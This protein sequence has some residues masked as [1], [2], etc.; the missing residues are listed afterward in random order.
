MI[1][2]LIADDHAIFR[3]GIG[4]IIALQ[5]DMCVC[6]EAMN[7]ED[8]LRQLER[9]VSTVLV[10]DMSMPG[11]SGIALIGQVK[12]VVPRL[13]IL[14]LSMHEQRQYVIQAIRSGADGYVTKASSSAEMLKGIR[15]VASG[16]MFIS[17]T[18]AEQL[19]LYLREP[20]ER[21]PHAAL[22]SR[23]LQVFQMLLKGLRVSEI[24][25]LLHLS[26]KT[27]STHKTRL[28][29]KLG[30]GSVTELV[31]YAIRHGLIKEE[32]AL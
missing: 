9:R 24:A 25:R 18:L 10:L 23:E 32:Q 14:V 15:A 8:L 7:G 16:K 1:D 28:Q 21:P 22:T 27:I 19:A 26:E 5:P 17:G 20:V 4:Q 31:R 6:G 11:Q 13:P 2:V 29:C 30:L 3:E 12:S